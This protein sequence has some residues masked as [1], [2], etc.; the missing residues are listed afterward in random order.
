V[1]PGLLHAVVLPYI[2]FTCCCFLNHKNIPQVARS[3]TARAKP[4]TNT[5]LLLLLLLLACQIAFRA[6]AALHAV[7]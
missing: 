4:L 3:R 5:S 6:L 2:G 7:L 1:T